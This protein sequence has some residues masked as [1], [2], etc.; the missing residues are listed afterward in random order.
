MLNF[1]DSL[2]VILIEDNFAIVS[3]LKN[4]IEKNNLKLVTFNRGKTY[5]II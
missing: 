1:I 4:Y 2:T 3:L 5:F